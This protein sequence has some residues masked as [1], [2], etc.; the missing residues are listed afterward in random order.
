VEGYGR[1][2]WHILCWSFQLGWIGPDGKRL[3]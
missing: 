2:S 1:H 3:I